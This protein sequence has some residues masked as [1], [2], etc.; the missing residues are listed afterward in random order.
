MSP[1][2]LE[3]I[4][5]GWEENC[6]VGSCTGLPLLPRLPLNQR[7]MS[8]YNS[9]HR[10]RRIRGMSWLRP[11]NRAYEKV[12]G[13]DMSQRLLKGKLERDLFVRREKMG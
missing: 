13:R 7:R 4:W 12:E 9:H 11:Q 1:R 8:N 2:G 6:G 3:S 5:V 10:R